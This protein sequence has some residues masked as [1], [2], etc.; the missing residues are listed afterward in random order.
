MS[1]FK[2]PKNLRTMKI[3][4]FKFTKEEQAIVDKLIPTAPEKINGIPFTGLE[5][6]LIDLCYGAQFMG[7]MQT[8]EVAYKLVTRLNPMAKVIF[9]N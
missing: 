7:Q 5:V 9:S 6:A 1:K 3:E 2:L 4:D 8:L